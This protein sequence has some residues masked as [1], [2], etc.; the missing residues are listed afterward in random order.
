MPRGV[1]AMMWFDMEEADLRRWRR[2]AMLRTVKRERRE[3]V[4]RTKKARMVGWLV[5]VAWVSEWAG[6]AVAVGKVV[7]CFRRRD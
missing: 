6:V 5:L 7:L 3:N 1:L 2:W 4:M